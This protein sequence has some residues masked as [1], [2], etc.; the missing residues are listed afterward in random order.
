MSKINVN[1][2]TFCNNDKKCFPNQEHTEEEIQEI[3]EPELSSHRNAINTDT[4]T[5]QFIQIH[6]PEKKQSI[7]KSLLI[8]SQLNIPLDTPN[9]PISN[10]TFPK[11]NKVNSR[12]PFVDNIKHF[13]NFVSDLE[14]NKEK[15]IDEHLI[16]DNYPFKSTNNNNLDILQNK[17]SLSQIPSNLTP[18]N[19]NM[20]NNIN[21]SNSYQISD[22][23]SIIKDLE[24]F[25]QIALNDISN[26][27][28]PLRKVSSNNNQFHNQ[29]QVIQQEDKSYNCIELIPKEVV[30]NYDKV[31]TSGTRGQHQTNSNINTS[32]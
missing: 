31:I 8:K 4:N 7:S 19:K 15:N 12:K 32:N 18:C 6:L 29:Q 17:S 2:N 13:K 22:N 20:N 11:R 24:R 5:N 1:N 21:Y 10:Q 23:D 9:M 14:E 16:P 30:Q 26:I 25:R 27:D 28:I 3:I